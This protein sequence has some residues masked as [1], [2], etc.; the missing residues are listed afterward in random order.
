MRNPKKHFVLLGGAL[1]FAALVACSAPRNNPLDANNP[2]RKLSGIEGKVLSLSLPHRP[3]AGAEVEF[4]SGQRLTFSDTHGRF[5]LANVHRYNG[6]LHVAKPG[7]HADSLYLQWDHAPQW[8]GELYLNAVPRV[9]SLIFYSSLINRYPSIQIL[10]LFVKVRL[11][12][13][14]KDIDSVLFE[15][16]TLHFSSILIYDTMD[17]FYEREHIP[18]SR[19]NVQSAE[20]IIGHRFRIMVKDTY[21]HCDTVQTTEIRRIIRDEVQLKSPAGHDTVSTTPTLYWEPITPGYSFT[22]TVEVRTDEADPQLVWQK[23][24]LPSGTSS[25]RVD[26]P[27]PESPNNNYIWAVWVIDSFGNRARSK[28]KSFQVQ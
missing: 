18:M 24:G 19:L 22:Y 14:D 10:E 13:A 9:D 3:I 7:F 15:S 20:E 8:H 2:D 27:L 21:G 11:S 26:V 4:P 1:L 6:W 12:D 16:P 5:S 25:V 23:T 17:R 28:F